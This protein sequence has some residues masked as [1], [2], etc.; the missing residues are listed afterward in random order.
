LWAAAAGVGR[1]PAL[2]V[3]SFESVQEDLQAEL[4]FELVVAAWIECRGWVVV[5]FGRRWD[6]SQH[7]HDVSGRWAEGGRGKALG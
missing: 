7:L 3:K 2:L 6:V 4:E 5:P 1:V